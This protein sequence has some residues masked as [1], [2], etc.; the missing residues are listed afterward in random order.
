[1]DACQQ[2]R[3]QIPG[4]GAM[5]E[6]FAGREGRGWR[7]DGTSE[8]RHD[9]A[10]Q[11]IGREHGAMTMGPWGGGSSAAI[12]AGREG[13]AEVA[14]CDTGNGSQ[15]RAVALHEAAGNDMEHARARRHRQ[16]QAR[17]QESGEELPGRKESAEG[18]A[19]RATSSLAGVWCEPRGLSSIPATA[20]VGVAG[21]RGEAA[22]ER[23]RAPAFMLAPVCE[24][25][26]PAPA[27]GGGAII[28]W[29][30][31][32]RLRQEASAGKIPHG[33]TGLLPGSYGHA[34]IG[35]RRLVPDDARRVW[36]WRRVHHSQPTMA[37]RTTTKNGAIDIV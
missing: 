22:H 5:T 20:M 4:D 30:Q 17:Q 13:V 16:H 10:W 25:V 6:L 21:M 3:P 18:Q 28:E 36:A 27:A 34:A 12:F 24:V 23:M 11:C 33:W 15:P 29:Q 37:S 7:N 19:Q 31:R 32:R 8:R 9:S 14:D 1:M 26:V 35:L 2:Q